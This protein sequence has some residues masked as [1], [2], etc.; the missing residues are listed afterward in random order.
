MS[1]IAMVFAVLLIALGVGGFAL[2][3]PEQRSMTALIPAIAGVLIGLCGVM[4]TKPNLRMHAMHGA[5]LVGVLGFIAPL[6]RIIPQTIKGSP[7]EGLALF[8]QAGMAALCL[9]FV[10]LCVRS[11]VAA[12]RTRS[13]SGN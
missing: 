13:V 1:K 6:G 5:A 2:A 10:I 11:F 9:V 7:P 12:R 4:A 8:S 3:R